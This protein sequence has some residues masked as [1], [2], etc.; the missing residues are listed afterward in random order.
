MAQ[1]HSA[2][3]QELPFSV[4]HSSEREAPQALLAQL[5]AA[6]DRLTEQL[7]R[8]AELELSLWPAENQRASPWTE[9]PSLLDSLLPWD[10]SSAASG[11][12]N[13]RYALRREQESVSIQLDVF[14][15]IGWLLQCAT[16]LS[17]HE[18]AACSCP[19]R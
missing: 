12:S 18:L 9:K 1:K 13:A 5:R 8:N 17:R 16:S 15:Q 19:G 6:E 4:Q 7:D 3:D 14:I 2:E 11:L 10:N